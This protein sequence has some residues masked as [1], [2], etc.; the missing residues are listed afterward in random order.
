MRKV[1][2]LRLGLA[3]GIAGAL[4]CGGDG[5]R[6]RGAAVAGADTAAYE[7]AIRLADA[8][9]RRERFEDFLDDYPRSPLR[10]LVYR[11][12]FELRVMEDESADVGK[13]LKDA[14]R[15]EKLP[16]T[17]AALHYALFEHVGREATGDVN[18]TVK[19]LLADEAPLGS[20]LYNAVAWDLAEADREL[21]QALELAERAVATA[22]DS[23]MRATAL[24]TRGWVHYQRREYPAAIADLESAAAGLKE[25]VP[26]VQAHL[27]RAYDA[28]GKLAEARTVY[29]DLLVAQEIPEFRRRVEGIT[30]DL[31]E[32]V[33]KV[34]ADLDE[35]RAKRTIA[36]P[37][38]TLTDYKGKPVRL[39]A[40]KGQV[41][42]L[43]FWHPT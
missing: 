25:P 1:V 10:G 9:P 13:F 23:L 3:L 33:P 14:L 30:R 41:V 22:P 32:S 40:L 38:F 8:G 27:A 20:D 6:N 18:A 28:G 12:L 11:R 19:A 34:M 26:D 36:A 39:S 4:A 5:G 31:G 43:N 29:L 37:D 24:D 35:R 42:L 16:E 15:K 7:A 17:R 2:L 21:D